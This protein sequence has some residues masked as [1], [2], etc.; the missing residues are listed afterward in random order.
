MTIMIYFNGKLENV[1]RQ[2]FLLSCS[3]IRR[4]C[5]CYLDYLIKENELF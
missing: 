5:D 4:N 2:Q 3:L 1:T